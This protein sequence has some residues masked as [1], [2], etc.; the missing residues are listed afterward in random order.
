MKRLL[1]FIFILVCGGSETNHFVAAKTTRSSATDQKIKYSGGD[2]SSIDQ[3]IV[4]E[5]VQTE[6]EGTEAEYAWIGKKFPGFKF[7][8]KGLVKKGDKKYDR[9]FG[10]KADGTNADFYF[11]ITLFVG[12]M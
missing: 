4:I 3:A 11:D 5:N 9:V 7:K 10:I 8:S 1:F 2:G 12:K 6:V